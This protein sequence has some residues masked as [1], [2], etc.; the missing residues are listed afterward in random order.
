MH[1]QS[2]AITESNPVLLR[3]MRGSQ[4]GAAAASSCPPSVEARIVNPVTDPSWDQWITAH[5]EATVFHT[6]AW[7]RVLADTYG[8]QP[9]YLRLS[10]QDKPVALVPLM[11]VRTLLTRT[12][13]VCLPFSDY[14]PPLMSSSSF[15]SAPILK[16]LR[17]VARERNWSYLE[18]RDDAIL[19][20]NAMSS[21]NYYGH[22]LD[23]S[24][25]STALACNFSSSARRAL[26]KAERSELTVSIG[27]TPEAM[28]R[29]YRLHLRTRRK[30]GVPPQPCSFFSNIQKHI[31]QPGYGFIVTVERGDRPIAAAVFFKFRG[32]A[33]YK[34]GASDE[35]WQDLRG[36]NLAMAAAIKYLAD[37]GA[38]SLHLGRT[39]KENKGLRH[40][41]LSFGTREHEISYGKFSIS[42]DSWAGK[43]TRRSTLP[44][45]VF[46]V[47]PAPVNRLAGVLLYPHLD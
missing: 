32:R 25:G 29:F 17:Q 22:T 19:P 46:R 31:I 12:R 14:C 43:R 27:T 36:N 18:L 4:S 2:R 39:D 1:G 42:T 23:L 13:G 28:R 5:A 34:F 37:S 30:H 45:R 7:A 9:C 24:I 10:I 6:S 15:G 3:A 47:L 11:E 40:F 16:K 35:R 21:E 44:N 33:I 38:Q 20:E 26:R 8:H 41:K